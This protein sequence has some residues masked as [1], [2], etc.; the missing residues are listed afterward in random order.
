LLLGGW[1]GGFCCW[2]GG[3]VGVAVGWSAVGWVAIGVDHP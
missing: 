2:V 3:R 1:A